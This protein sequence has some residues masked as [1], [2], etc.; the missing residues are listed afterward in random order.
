MV[1]W[2]SCPKGDG[3]APGWSR[4]LLAEGKRK[5]EKGAIVFDHELSDPNIDFKRVQATQMADIIH[6]EVAAWPGKTYVVPF[7]SSGAGTTAACVR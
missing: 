4:G 2:A 5:S 3:A 1:V 6:G 7:Y